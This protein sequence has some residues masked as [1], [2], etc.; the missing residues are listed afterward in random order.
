MPDET[1]TE[2]VVP[3]P[4]PGARLSAEAASPSAFGAQ[5]SSGAETLAEVG[6]RENFK[7]RQKQDEALRQAQHTQNLA[8]SNQYDSFDIQK[9]HDPDTGLLNQN[10][11]PQS[12]QAAQD[13]LKQFDDLAAKQQATLKDPTG[14][15]QAT[16]AAMTAVKRNDLERTLFH[17]EAG[18]NEQYA[19][20]QDQTKLANTTTLAVQNASDPAAVLHQLDVGKSVIAEAGKRNQDD[21]D[22]IARHQFDYVSASHVAV[23]RQQIA[24]GQAPLAQAWY[25]QHKGELNARDLTEATSLTDRGSVS[26]QAQDQADEILKPKDDGTMPTLADALPRI[27][28][29]ADV[30]LRDETQDRVLRGLNVQAQAQAQDQKKYYDQGLQIMQDQSNLLGARSPAVEVLRDKMG[31]D[32]WNT[33]MA[34]DY[35]NQKRE[36][37]TT[38]LQTYGSLTAKLH[39]PTTPKDFGATGL[40]LYQANLSPEDYKHFVNAFAEKADGKTGPEMAGILTN[41]EVAT[42]LMKSMK[43]DPESEKG[44]RFQLDLDQRVREEEA[45]TGK[46]LDPKGVKDLADGMQNETVRKAGMVGLTDSAET[47]IY[48]LK[49]SELAGTTVR[50]ADYAARDPAG[51]AQDRQSLQGFV[52]KMGRTPDKMTPDQTNRALAQMIIQRSLAKSGD[53]E[54]AQA[55][56]ERFLGILR[57][58]PEHARI[59][60]QTGEVMKPAGSDTPS[61][62]DKIRQTVQTGF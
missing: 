35:K 21:A 39:D 62:A 58:T 18:Q 34:L 33:L 40:S 3:Q 11:G 41:R 47:P 44:M 30:K 55:A 17:Y 38:D 10:L 26:Q 46:K 31:P 60:P 9:L 45:Q 56:Y 43:I 42:G 29:I 57:E 32:R 50:F 4:G 59:D 51:A 7:V 12:H 36:A 5:I 48:E 1:F 6:Q 14:Q 61:G 49:P 27:R 13:L 23:M 53:R 20:Q 52:A 8:I 37:P 15:Q 24:Q 54:G 28:A 2:S 25:N 16:V 19:K 22:T